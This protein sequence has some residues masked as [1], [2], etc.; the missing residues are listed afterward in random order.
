[1]EFD[2]WFTHASEEDE[3]VS[4]RSLDDEGPSY[5]VWN[6]RTDLGNK[7]LTIGMKFPTRKKYRE[8]LRDWAVR[9]GWDLKFQHNETKKIIATCKPG[10][11]WRIHA[12]KVMKI[13]TFQIKSIKDKHN[14]AHMTE[15][16]QANYKYLGK[17]I[18]NIIR[19]NLNK[20]LISL[21]NKVRRD[22][23]I[24]CSL[25]KVY[26]I[27]KYALQLIKGNIKL[28]SEMLYDYC[29]TMDKYNPGSTL[30][31]KVD[32]ELS[33]HV[34]Q[35]MYFYLFGLKEGFL[36]GCSPII[37]LDGCFLKSIYRGQLLTAVGRDGNDNIYPIVMAYVEIEKYDSWEWFFN[38]LLRDI[39]SPD[40]KG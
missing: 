1:M 10:C 20:G 28:Q 4:L 13:A 36:D 15:N 17:R 11:D 38:L 26:R 21:K 7:D 40:E 35:R 8:V 6:E 16:K 37:G 22:V 14:W 32:R 24:D 27:K 30:V 5:P 31:L 33:P 34:L 25:H 29:A 2:G 12:S 9:R 18:E 19:D 39:G 3:L 23:E